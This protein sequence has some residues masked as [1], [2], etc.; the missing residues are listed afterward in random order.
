MLALAA[1]TILA[2]DAD[3][4][5][6]YGRT[7]TVAVCDDPAPAIHGIAHGHISAL[8]SEQPTMGP[9][10]VL[11]RAPFAA[12]AQLGDGSITN[13]Y[14]WGVFICL[15]ATGLLALWLAGQALERRA[16][17]VVA[18]A[19]ACGA[20]VNPLTF[21]ALAIG[22][23]EEP[24]AAA[25]A[26][27]AVVAAFRSRPLAA[28]LLLGAAIAT[29]QWALLAAGPVLLAALPGRWRQTALAA[30]ALAA[31]L[32]LPVALGDPGR[33]RDATRAAASPPA[34]A[35]PANVWWPLARVTRDEQLAPGTEARRPP[36]AVRTLAHWLVLAL[37]AGLSLLVLARTRTPGLDRLL[38]LAALIFLLRCM[39]DPYT[40]SYHHW[41]MLV[42]LGAYEAIGRRRMPLLA[43]A[44]GVAL[45]WTSYH[46]SVTGN[47]DAL[48]RFYLAWTLPLALALGWITLRAARSEPA[49]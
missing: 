5:A 35:T 7:C 45:W 14:R 25:L 27:A 47:A 37:A 36:R 46:V 42:A 11:L 44:A 26:V 13:E 4:G 23:P 17:P 24:L 12:L 43:I 15:F 18:A 31:V 2:I 32:Y 6:D 19:F 40:F 28:G 20:L 1:S 30:A 8:W 38:A 41:P 10:S 48:Q 39:L 16:H 21:R 3:K 22:H 9:A 29:K 33:F 49:A 34:N